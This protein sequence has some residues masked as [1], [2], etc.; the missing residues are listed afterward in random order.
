MGEGQYLRG[1]NAT[2]QA[3]PD[4]GF[5]FNGWTGDADGNDNPLSLFMDSDKVVGATF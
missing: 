2:V 5:L 1:G 4:P 3:T